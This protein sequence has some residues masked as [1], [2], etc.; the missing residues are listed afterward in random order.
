MQH[1]TWKTIGEE[2]C[3]HMHIVRELCHRLVTYMQNSKSMHLVQQILQMTLGCTTSM[4]KIKVIGQTVRTGEHRQTDKQTNKQ[5]DG[6]T[7]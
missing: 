2:K 4:L 1:Y 7:D 3:S 5:M 6:P